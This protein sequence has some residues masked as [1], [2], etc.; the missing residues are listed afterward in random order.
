MRPCRIKGFSS[1]QVSDRPYRK[2][3]RYRLRWLA[4]FA[5]TLPQ[6]MLADVIENICNG[7]QVYGP[8]V[9]A[10][11]FHLVERFPPATLMAFLACNNVHHDV[12]EAI[13]LRVM[14]LSQQ[15]GHLR[16]CLV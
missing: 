4:L 11:C 2:L 12:I 14:P 16:A 7:A 8:T 6:R 10:A 9:L 1:L 3:W 15:S 5:C 13:L